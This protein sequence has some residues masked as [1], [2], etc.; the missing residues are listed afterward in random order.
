MEEEGAPWQGP[1]ATDFYIGT[2]W[3]GDPSPGKLWLDATNSSTPIIGSDT[4]HFDP[5]HPG[6]VFT[7]RNSNCQWLRLRLTYAGLDQAA[8]MRVAL[9]APSADVGVKLVLADYGALELKR[10]MKNSK[11]ERGKHEV[12]EKLHA[13]NFTGDGG[14]L[15]SD[16]QARG[17][18]L[19]PGMEMTVQPHV[20][21]GE[22]ECRGKKGLKVAG[23][24]MCRCR[25]DSQQKDNR[26]VEML[27]KMQ[28][29][30]LSS[31]HG[32]SAFRWCVRVG[33]MPFFSCAFYLKSCWIRKQAVGPSRTAVETKPDDVD[34]ELLDVSK[35][36]ASVL[37][38]EDKEKRVTSSDAETPI[39]YVPPPV[40]LPPP[41]PGST[42]VHEGPDCPIHS[43]DAIQERLLSHETQ[44]VLRL[45]T[46]DLSASPAASMRMKTIDVVNLPL[47]VVL[48]LSTPD[49]DTAPGEIRDCLSIECGRSD[50]MANLLTTLSNA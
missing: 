15:R 16:E 27:I 45:I 28:A 34:A 49:L 14:R 23:K 46:A 8:A 17:T 47:D 19:Q 3:L 33:G 48:R 18:S 35:V 38:E 29:S 22:Q 1:E 37:F 31:D 5:P 4:P 6:Y 42:K 44:G 12:E 50:S 36:P 21:A 20:N 13:F 11:F 9:R 10:N 32:G 41:V 39:V 25:C 43:H 2:T 7:A 26:T 24:Y 30:L 40:T